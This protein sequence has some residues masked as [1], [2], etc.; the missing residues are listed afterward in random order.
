MYCFITSQINEIQHDECHTVVAMQS[1]YSWNVIFFK[2]QLQVRTCA[3]CFLEILA[4]VAFNGGEAGGGER[5]IV[6]IKQKP[7][8]KSKRVQMLL[9]SFGKDISSFFSL[10]F[11]DS[12]GF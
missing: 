7:D 11:R 6:L 1:L 8:M 4:K 12:Y 10:L 2:W 9:L 5:E 3:L